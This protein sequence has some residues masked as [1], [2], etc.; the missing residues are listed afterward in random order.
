MAHDTSSDENEIDCVYSVQKKL[1]TK[2][3][4]YSCKRIKGFWDMQKWGDPKP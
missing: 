1:Q 3:L 2:S 4:S